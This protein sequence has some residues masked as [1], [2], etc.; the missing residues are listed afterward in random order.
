MFD[1][2]AGPVTITLPDAG[3]RFMSMQV[4]DEDQHTQR[5]TTAPAAN[6][7]A[8]R[9]GHPLSIWR[10]AMCTI[11]RTRCANIIQTDQM[12]VSM[13]IRTSAV[14]LGSIPTSLTFMG[15]DATHAKGVPHARLCGARRASQRSRHAARRSHPRKILRQKFG[16]QIFFSKWALGVHDSALKAAQLSAA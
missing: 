10:Q 11:S 12:R 16:T 13:T 14:T 8:G 1:F 9:D 15:K 4:I 7:V 5:S 6:G 2:D 3:K